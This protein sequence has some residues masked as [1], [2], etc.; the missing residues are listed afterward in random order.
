[1][2]REAVAAVAD[3]VVSGGSFGRG[4]EGRVESE[5]LRMETEG[6]SRVRPGLGPVNDET[7]GEPTSDR[8]GR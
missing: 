7:K 5:L 2:G 6:M 4:Q 8:G 3:D 1:M